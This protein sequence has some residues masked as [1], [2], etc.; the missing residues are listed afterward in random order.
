MNEQYVEGIGCCL[1]VLE[2]ICKKLRK[3]RN[4]PVRIKVAGAFR[5]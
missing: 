2:L 5:V 4:T 3:I 1:T